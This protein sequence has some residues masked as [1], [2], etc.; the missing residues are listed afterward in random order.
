[1]GSEAPDGRWPPNIPQREWD[2]W[3]SFFPMEAELWQWLSRKLR[4][5]ADLS[6]ADW[7]VLDALGNTPGHAARA[8]EL[9]RRTA[10]SKSRLSQ[11]AA[12]M[13]QR[14]LLR[15]HA[16]ADDGRGLVIELTPRGL[17]TFR[18]AQVHRARHIRQA[19]IEALEPGELDALITASARIR[20]NLRRLSHADP[21]KNND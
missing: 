16:A 6:E 14:G 9:A 11:H 21:V 2:L 18:T 19:V 13:T 8:F 5:D 15:Q 3:T 4:D 20:D 17:A 12:R 10:F 7:Q 1:M